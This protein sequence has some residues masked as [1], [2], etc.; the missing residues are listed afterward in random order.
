[1]L[2]PAYDLTFYEF[3]DERDTQVW[4]VLLCDLV[5]GKPPL[6]PLYFGTGWYWYVYAIMNAAETLQ[7]P[8]TKGWGYRVRDGYPYLTCMKTTK[9]E[10]KA[11]EPVFR[12]MIRPF[13][14]DFEGVWNPL[15]TELM[16][17]YREAKKTY[18]IKEWNDIK[19][20][21]NIELLRF[22]LDYAFVINRKEAETHMMM[23]VA[24]NYINGLFQQMWFEIFGKQAPIDPTFAALMSGYEAQ[25][26]KVNRELW[27][28]SRKIPGM[29]LK[30]V[31]E[32][33]DNKEVLKEL[34]KS[35]A[36]RAWLKEYGEFLMEHGW[37]CERMHAYD[38]P[39]WIEKPEL[40]IG[41]VKVYM[42]QEEFPFDVERVRLIA[43]REAAE[44]EVL[45]KLS[46]GQKEW[47]ET[48]MKSAQKSGYWSEDHTY[49]CDFYVGA[50][51]RCIIA[52]LGN[53]F[54]E[55]GT[56][57]SAED[58]HFLHAHEIRKAAV[59]MKEVNL[60]PYVERRKSAWEKAYNT[61]PP[62]FFGNIEK[63]GEVLKSDP[64]LSV[65][66]QLP[67]VREELKA[68][69]YGAAAAPGVVEGPARVIM[70]AN[71]L[72]DLKEGEILVAPGTSAAWT[73]AFSLIKG[74]ITD[75]GG[76]LSHPV[77]MARECGIPCVAGCLQGTQKIK[78]GDKVKIDGDLGVV[79]I[80][81]K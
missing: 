5:H 60:R 20:L 19:K 37:R 53:R 77:I 35:E 55:A 63:A 71:R 70:E 59:P 54:A 56:I 32:T 22:F 80:L 42:N 14:E 36:G 23:L 48:L 75:G 46:P 62:T 39:A 67:I 76:A 27:K 68:D 4:D 72:S 66:T 43:K 2:H 7:L 31:L 64:T 24:A 28:L 12:E 69:L 26:H 50:L 10:A 58:I 29:G 65:S 17:V 81:S 51:G 25:D 13:I 3:D 8:T 30:T 11:R 6:K 79:F 41:R 73:V 1:M 57:D 44:K 40:A 45:A 47:F 34:E 18:R 38:T 15:K 61:D 74:L 21:S 9:E 78:T 16:G 52:E 49:F 33:K